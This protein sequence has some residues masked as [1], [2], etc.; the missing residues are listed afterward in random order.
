MYPDTGAVAPTNTKIWV[1]EAAWI[2]EDWEAWCQSSG[3]ILTG[4]DGEVALTPSVVLSGDVMYTPAEEL[5]ANSEYSFDF[6]CPELW[7]GNAPDPKL[8]TTG[9]GPATTAPDRVEAVETEQV[10][11]E[12]TGSCGAVHVGLYETTHTG[13][14]TLVDVHADSD[15]DPDT[16]VGEVDVV[17]SAEGVIVGDDT[18]GGGWLEADIGEFA[19]VRF[20]TIDLAGNFSGWSDPVLLDM[21]EDEV[22]GEGCACALDGR[23]PE[24]PAG[25]LVLG[26]AGLIGLRRRRARAGETAAAGS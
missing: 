7:S 11:S 21:R 20:A 18:C 17:G 12:S 9:E 3:P 8:F 2:V 13:F 14:V 23:G 22:E 24:L 26:L 16:L 6:N 4:P 25:L 15:L 1:M 10:H 19:E 5:A